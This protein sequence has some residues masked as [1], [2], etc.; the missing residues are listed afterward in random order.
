MIEVDG[1]VKTFPG[2]VRALDRLTLR[3]P[4]GVIYGLLGPNGAGKTTLIRVLAT[5]LPVETGTARVAGIDV[6]HHPAAVRARIGL[7]GQYAAVD[8]YLTGRENVQMVGL[9]YGLTRREARRRTSEVLER[10]G[11]VPAADRPVRTY[12]GGMRRR[13]DLAAS[14][15]GRPTVLF[16]DEPTT[17]VDPASRRE[18]W[19]L[20]GD[21]VGAGTTVLL[22]TQYLEEADRLADR[23]AVIDRGRLVCEGTGDQLKDKAGA[24]VVELSV[25]ELDRAHVMAALSDVG[26][27]RRGR[28]GGLIVVPAPLGARSLHELL[29][30][31]DAAGI[32]PEHIGLRKPTLDEVFLTLTG[33]AADTPAAS[34]KAT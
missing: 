15:V 8:D 31:L 2:K 21:L 26:A 13:L 14:L 7:A 25:P 28:D 4:A 12:S 23:I 33:H 19:A 32:A 29:H 18:L 27:A 17:G 30:D 10:I 9:L 11:L 24:A 6:A 20:T 16:L 5:L 22:T 34:G 1:L 3:V